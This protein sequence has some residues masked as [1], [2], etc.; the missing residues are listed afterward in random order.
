MGIYARE[1]TVS[2]DRSKSEIERTL[3]RYGA[4]SFMYGWDSD[5]RG[6]GFQFRFAN[7]MLRFTIPIP[8]REDFRKTGKGRK[9]PG[10]EGAVDRAWE[11]AIRQRWRALAIAIKAKLEAVTSGVVGFDVEFMPYAVMPDGRTVAEHVGPELALAY[12]S[13]KMPTQMLGWAGDGKGKK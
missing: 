6:A 5:K 11:Q 12:E 10:G 1:T 4:T 3:T 2:V 8:D 13:G 9:R 7:R